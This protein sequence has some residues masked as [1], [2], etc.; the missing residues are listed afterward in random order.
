MADGEVGGLWRMDR[1]EEGR[2]GEG[3]MRYEYADAV[4]RFDHIRAVGRGMGDGAVLDF[5]RR[6]ATVWGW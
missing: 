3:A 5:H 1:K 2:A 6:W 4:D